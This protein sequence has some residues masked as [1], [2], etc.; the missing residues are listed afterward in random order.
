MSTHTEVLDDNSD[1]VADVAATNGPGGLVE[2]VVT[3]EGTGWAFTEMVAKSTAYG[4]V[5]TITLS[6]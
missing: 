6:K 5:T 1:S 2:L 3:L 4:D